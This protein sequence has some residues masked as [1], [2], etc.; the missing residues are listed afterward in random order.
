MKIGI[1][2]PGCFGDNINSTL[3]FE[4]LKNHFKCE[5]D[6]HT[7][8]TYRSAFDNNPFIN[9]LFDYPATGKNDALNLVNVLPERVGRMGYNLVLNPHPMINGEKWN[10]L[11]KPELGTN[12]ML[13]WVRQLEELNVPVP[14]KLRT[15]LVLTDAE[16]ARAD[17]FFAQFPTNGRRNVL[18]EVSHESGQSFWNHDWTLAVGRHLLNGNTNVFI[19][20]KNDGFETGELKKDAKGCVVASLHPLSVRE[21]AHIFNKCDVFICVS[22]GLTNACNTDYCKTDGKWVEVINSPTVA[23]APIRSDGK[24]FWHERDV[25][26]FLKCLQ[27]NAI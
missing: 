13:A 5:I 24:V 21:C 20:R 8:V 1:I 22:S 26:S 7:S 16:K 19:S 9:R 23:S 6:V 27:D 11:T 2:Q 15:T 25:A 12:L 14:A 18:M 4:P 3:M 10:S 17:S